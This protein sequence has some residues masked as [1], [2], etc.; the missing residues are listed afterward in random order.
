MRF[1]SQETAMRLAYAGRPGLQRLHMPFRPQ[2]RYGYNQHDKDGDIN[3][4]GTGFQNTHLTP[5]P[6]P[7]V[8][9]MG[10]EPDSHLKES[11]LPGVL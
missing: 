3:Q 1:L 4:T 7:M 10:A 11:L 6:A 5:T 9:A 2:H 8:T